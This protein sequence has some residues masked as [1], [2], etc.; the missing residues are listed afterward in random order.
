[1][2]GCSPLLCLGPGSA[3]LQGA[4]GFTSIERTAYPQF[5]RLTTARV[6]HVFFT[7]TEDEAAWAR[8]RTESPE[9]LLALVVDL[10]CFQKMAR[11]CSREEIP[12]AVT[13]HVRHCLGLA[14]ET[15]PGHG[16][17]RTAK[18]HRGQV[19][20]RQGVTYDM[21]RARALAEAAIREAAQVRNH[22]PDLINVVVA[23][24]R[25]V[26]IT[27]RDGPEHG[28]AALEAIVGMERSHLWHAALA[29]N[30]RRLG[31]AAEAAGELETAAALAPTEGERRLLLS[32]LLDVR[33][34][35]A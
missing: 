27:E 12:Q 1:M 13:D 2:A 14:P 21:G 22:P 11:F 17:A 30:L 25:A 32:R 26:A 5:R 28:L 29:D 3:W 19:R 7:P 10:K 31:R 35:P 16:A 6:L 23:L 8:E 18:W 24:N 34:E 9:A 15:E 4:S 20:K 33:P